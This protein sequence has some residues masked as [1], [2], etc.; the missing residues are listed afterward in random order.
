MNTTLIDQ[1]T[2]KVAEQH[3]ILRGD[4]TAWLPEQQTLL[5][6]DLHLG[7]AEAMQKGGLPVPAGS[8]E[9][10]L[11]RLHHALTAAGARRLII[12]GDLFHH[13]PSLTPRRRN[14]ILAALCRAAAPL[15]P[16]IIPGNH[17]RLPPALLQ[18]A[19]LTLLRQGRPHRLPFRLFH[20]PPIAPPPGNHPPPL[21]H[22]T[23]RLKN[24]PQPG[25]HPPPDSPAPPGVPPHP[26]P[27]DHPPPLPFLAGH[28]HPVTRL[29]AA[30][31]RLRLPCFLLY[32][33]GIVLPAFGS[34]TGGRLFPRQSGLTRTAVFEGALIEL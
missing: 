17:D 18:K 12:L 4:R 15:T 31:E 24:T 3:I 2:C 11:A 28:I 9:S 23:A 25:D 34:F 7:K 26:A 33:T 8:D 14:Q 19:G 20:H 10:D 22:P 5:A 16:E 6:A 1:V 32:E 13:P 30:G 27:A 21:R 29:A